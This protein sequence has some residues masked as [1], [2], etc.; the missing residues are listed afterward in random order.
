MLEL[1]EIELL[2]IRSRRFG[3]GSAE[4][5]MHVLD[6]HHADRVERI[7]A[8]EASDMRRCIMRRTGGSS[9]GAI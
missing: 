5:I 9:L 6:T 3:F 8:V 2:Q 4:E 1:G 7:V